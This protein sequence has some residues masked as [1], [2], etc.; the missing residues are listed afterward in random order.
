MTTDNQDEVM[1]QAAQ[2]AAQEQ[3]ERDFVAA[4]EQLAQ[5]DAAR[6]EAEQEN[7][8]QHEAAQDQHTEAE[9]SEQQPV[10]VGTVWIESSDE[11]TEADIQDIAAAFE[12][13]PEA[14]NENRPEAAAVVAEGEASDQ[15]NAKEP[16]ERVNA[17]DEAISSERPADQTRYTPFPFPADGPDDMRQEP[18]EGQ[19]QPETLTLEAIERDP[20]NAVR[21]PMPETEDCALLEKIE[22]TAGKL[23][24]DVYTQLYD[25]GES[26]RAADNA[27]FQAATTRQAEARAA[28]EAQACE[29]E[30][31]S[32]RQ[33]AALEIDPAD[34]FRYAAD[35]TTN[36]EQGQRE[37]DLGERILA[38][39]TLLGVEDS[40]EHH[41]FVA[42]QRTYSERIDEAPNQDIAALW[43]ASRLAHAQDYAADLCDQA[44]V[45]HGLEG[46]FEEAAALTYE[47][48]THREIA[49]SI[50]GDG[51]EQ[52][53]QAQEE[54]R[55][56]V[57]ASMEAAAAEALGRSARVAVM[58][59]GP[60]SE[61]Q[62][63]QRAEAPETISEPSARGRYEAL[64]PDEQDG[65]AHVADHGYNIRPVMEVAPEGTYIASRPQSSFDQSE[66]DYERGP[67]RP[68]LAAYVALAAAQA[69]ARSDERD[70]RDSEPVETAAEK[71]KREAN[72]TE[73]A[74]RTE[75]TASQSTAEPGTTRE[76][77][78]AER[79]EL[80]A[81]RDAAEEA[82]H[83]S[84]RGM[85]GAGGGRGGMSF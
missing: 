74:A 75:T 79:A 30:A 68:G 28:I 21:L 72:S 56:D 24:E 31:G 38:L 37:R 34:S 65:R 22:Q 12:P 25:S 53:P 62:Q 11:L 33:P 41:A 4:R 40:R 3:A 83:D 2:R 14:S 58:V 29:L 63:G 8:R 19:Q 13:V 6:R 42:G 84:G 66:T 64:Q 23:A 32:D 61:Q 9:P 17:P 45:K 55:E 43:L 73:L 26:D 39:E 50:R 10:H 54:G 49:S 60:T 52:N 69:E 47:G 76:L 71:E 81:M 46:Q 27:I 80:A 59:D 82:E 16:A 5:Q 7:T 51:P 1:R 77:T 48:R 78:R 44:G 57:A 85:G 35:A 36:T 18:G 20:W 15:D 67:V 70:S